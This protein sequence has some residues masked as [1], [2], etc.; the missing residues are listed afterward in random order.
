EWLEAA[1]QS[2]S[3][4]AQNNIQ[5]KRVLYDQKMEDLKKDAER[6]TD[7][8]ADKNVSNAEKVKDIRSNRA[9]E[10][11]VQRGSEAFVLGDTADRKLASVNTD[12]GRFI[13]QHTTETLA[14][15]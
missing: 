14:L 6:A 7:A 10:K 11:L 2:S 3:A 5:E 8:V 12:T 9:D 1:K 4:Q 13:D 15:L